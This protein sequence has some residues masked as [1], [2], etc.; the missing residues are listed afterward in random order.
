MC[1][2]A[3]VSRSGY[4][5]WLRKSKVKP[6]D[7]DDYLLIKEVFDQGK[8]RYGWRTIQMKLHASGIR[9]NH[10]KI[11]RI[12]NT[13][14]L[15]TKIRKRNPYKEIMKKTREHRTFNNILARQFNQQQPNK[16]F[17]TDI[18]YVPFSGNMAYL[19]AVK[20]IASR[21]IV[22]WNLS[23]HLQMDLVFDTLKNLEA[24][25]NGSSLENALIH[26][27]RGFH[28]TSPDFISRVK[29]L[30][31]IQSMSRK[32]NCVDNAPMES[33]FG[34]FKDEVDYRSCITFEELKG[35][36]AEYINHYNNGRRQWDL[37]KMTPV[38]YR[39][40]LLNENSREN[41]VH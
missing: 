3:R 38:E 26:S 4:Y 8:R 9:M 5:Q 15:V 17:C 30:N 19:S 31:L 32:G 34:H 28:Y 37:K 33:F 14:N 21:E 6:K 1:E 40:H 22:A 20:D 18:T 36:T 12:M 7:Y 25:Q 41:S 13:Y 35:L 23:R 16:V 29:K 24:N 10:K 11:S 27:D 39:K 2:V